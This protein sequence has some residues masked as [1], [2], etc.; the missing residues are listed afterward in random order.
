VGLRI[1]D[2]IKACVLAW[3]LR[4]IILPVALAAA[5]GAVA[6]VAYAAAGPDDYSINNVVIQPSGWSVVEGGDGDLVH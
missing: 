6:P 5:L 1:F 4:E 3:P 2:T